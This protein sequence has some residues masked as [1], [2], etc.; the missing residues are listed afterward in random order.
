MNDISEKL[1]NNR[2]YVL[3]NQRELYLGSEP[4]PLF[5]LG[6]FNKDNWNGGD[7]VIR[8]YASRIEDSENWDRVYTDKTKTLFVSFRHCDDDKQISF[9]LV[10]GNGTHKLWSFSWYKNRGRIDEARYCS[11]EMTEY[12]YIKLLE[13]I[14]RMSDFK[15]R[16]Y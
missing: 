3:K 5:L 7:A 15:F 8:Q 4:K 1:A 6:D 9:S 10:Y 13:V 14:E 11:A 12:D 16:Y 2:E